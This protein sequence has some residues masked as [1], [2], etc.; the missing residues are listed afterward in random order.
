MVSYSFSEAGGFHAMNCAMAALASLND[1]AASA[2]SNARSIKRAD[3]I[4]V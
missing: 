2:A 3:I 4:K 1:S